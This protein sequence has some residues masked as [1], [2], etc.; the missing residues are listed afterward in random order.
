M[1]VGQICPVLSNLSSQWLVGR[2]Y[3]GHFNFR[4][5]LGSRNLYYAGGLSTTRWHGK[6]YKPGRSANVGMCWLSRA[7]SKGG[8]WQAGR[9]LAAFWC[10]A[11]GRTTASYYN[12]PK[13]G[14]CRSNL[15]SQICPVNDWSG[16]FIWVISIFVA[17]LGSRNGGL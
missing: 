9:P 4:G 2:H 16:D 13:R 17:R 6:F 3:L 10:R 11:G 8:R 14:V 1:S 15:F 5:R 7:A 12:S